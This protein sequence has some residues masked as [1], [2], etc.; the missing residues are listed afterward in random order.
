MSRRL[1]A[2]FLLS[3]FLGAGTT[4]PDPDALLYHWVGG[5]DSARPHVEP[6]GGCGGHLEHCTLGRTATGA[7]AALAQSPALRIVPLE[8]APPAQPHL[9]LSI[10]APR[11]ILPQPRAP[12]APAV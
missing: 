6:A 12:P 8:P 9:V 7:G 1:V 5:S 10:V 11:G 4:L 3:V 2:L